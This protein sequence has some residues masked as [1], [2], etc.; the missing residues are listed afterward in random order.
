MKCCML[1]F[2]L[3][4]LLFSA[5]VSCHLFSYDFQC[6]FGISRLFWVIC[7]TRYLLVRNIWLI[8]C[9]YKKMSTQQFKS[10]RLPY[11]AEWLKPP[12][13]WKKPCDSYIVRETDINSTH[14]VHFTVWNYIRVIFCLIEFTWYQFRNNSFMPCVMLILTWEV[15]WQ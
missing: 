2:V 14:S 12:C 10:E 4:C 9:H 5:F 8:L 13:W 1:S 6:S 11:Y 3:G 15:Y 7:L